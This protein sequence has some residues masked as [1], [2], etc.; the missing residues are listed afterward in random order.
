MSN[1]LD[2]LIFIR[3][4]LEKLRD[5]DRIRYEG[6]GVFEEAR[7]ELAS[8]IA[9]YTEIAATP[10]PIVYQVMT[11]QKAA[12]ILLAATDATASRIGQSEFRTGELLTVLRA[13]LVTTIR[14]DIEASDV[15]VLAAVAETRTD[16]LAAIAV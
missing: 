12:E 2:G 14:G 16:L 6:A 4:R 5:E 10:A 15:T 8:V 9:N 13:D 3:G 7:Q 1:I 11:E